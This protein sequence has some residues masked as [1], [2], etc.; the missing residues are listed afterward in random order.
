MNVRKPT[1]R[2]LLSASAV[3]VGLAAARRARADTTTLRVYWWGA[4][5][6]E[7]RTNATN[8]LYMQR[9]SDIR[10]V[11]ETVGWGDYWTRLATQAAGHN[12]A[13]MIQ[14]DH[15]YIYEYSRRHAL[16]LLDPF[17]G[18]ELDL[19]A[20]SEDSIAGG[21]VD[22][23]I[24][25]VSLGLNSTSLIYDR[26]SFEK[27]GQEPLEWP[28]TWPDFAKRTIAFTKAAAREDYWAAQD[29]GGAGPALE[30]WLRE[31]GKLM[32]TAEGKFGA[33]DAEMANGSP[34]G[35]TCARNAAAFRPRCRR[36]RRPTSTPRW[37]RS[38]RLRSPSRIRI[39]W[40][41]IRRSTRTSWISPCIPRGRR[42]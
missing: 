41:G 39:S 11:G 22:G 17:V 7:K 23:K 26:Q 29:A 6:R 16:L 24:Y 9:N 4:T 31:R 8:A 33:D 3:A 36:W 10:I 42:G 20:F 38:A 32:Y 18:K 15:G 35:T 2:D 12:M 1:R 5:D 27:L 14:M 34:T 40:S 21:K 37:S 13:D 19:S 30:V 28:V 25:G